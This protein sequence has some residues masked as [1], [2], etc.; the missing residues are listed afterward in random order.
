[1]RRA[2]AIIAASVV[3]VLIDDGGGACVECVLE[4]QKLTCDDFSFHNEL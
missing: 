2:V 4:I 3:N 1:M